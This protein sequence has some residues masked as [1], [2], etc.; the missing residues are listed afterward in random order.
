MKIK[1]LAEKRL[2]QF[3]FVTTNKEI[4]IGNYKIA[5]QTDLPISDRAV[6]GLIV[7]DKGFDFKAIVANICLIIGLDDSFRHRPLYIEMVSRLIRQPANYCLARG[8]EAANQSDWIDAVGY[9][10]AALSFDGDNYDANYHLGRAYYQMY[11]TELAVESTLTLAYQSLRRAQAIDDRA[12]TDYYLTYVC[13][14]RQAFAESF[15]FAKRAL[16]RGLDADL[17]DGLIANMQIFEDRAKYE[18]GYRH[19]LAARYQEGLE[20]LLTISEQGQDD[21]RVQFFIALAYRSSGQLSTAL[22]YFNKARDLNSTNPDVY[23]DLGVCY[24]MLGDLQAAKDSFSDGLYKFPDNADL[25]CNMGIAHLHD[26]Q[27]DLAEAFLSQAK[28][29][30]PTGQSIL[31]ALAE[32]ARRRQ[33]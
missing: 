31:A 6:S 33:S 21:W 10:K 3:F 5:A 2:S 15:Q 30:E 22:Q 4:A 17:K 12:E 26:N 28:Q 19:V 13:F 18:T 24:L 29:L 20:A 25:L 1:T 27:L 7:E 16:Q 32:L 23:N 11:Q 8:I 14:H 9:F